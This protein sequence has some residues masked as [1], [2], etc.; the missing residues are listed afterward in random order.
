VVIHS[1]VCQII[2]AA[3]SNFYSTYY[4]RKQHYC[5]AKKLEYRKL[6]KHLTA[7]SCRQTKETTTCPHDFLVVDLLCSAASHDNFEQ[8]SKGQKLTAMRLKRSAC[9]RTNL[10]V[11][12]LTILGLTAGRM[13]LLEPAGILL[14][15][16]TR[17]RHN[18]HVK[19]DQ[20]TGVRAAWMRN[21]LQNANHLHLLPSFIL[22]SSH[23]PFTAGS[24][25]DSFVAQLATALP[26]FSPY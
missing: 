11:F 20:H 3:Y 17:M 26:S 1:I 15:I 8:V 25:T 12:F 6:L 21:I 4:T 14:T 16:Y 22:M 24:E 5:F 10:F 2:D 19:F 23:V 13:L 9:Q 18:L 7:R